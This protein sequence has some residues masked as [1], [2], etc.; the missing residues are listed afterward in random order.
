MLI[1]F[2]IFLWNWCYLCIYFTIILQWHIILMHVLTIY[3]LTMQKLLMLLLQRQILTAID[4]I[5]W[6][7]TWHVGLCNHFS[8]LYLRD[9]SSGNRVSVLLTIMA[10]TINSSTFLWKHKYDRLKFVNPST[11]FLMKT[12]SKPYITLQM[13]TLFKKLTLFLYHYES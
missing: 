8:K 9:C 5:K 6:S 4:W 11:R 2:N 3:E 13:L 10:Q 7:Y 12:F 1:Q